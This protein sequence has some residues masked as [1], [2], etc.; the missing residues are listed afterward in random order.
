MRRRSLR[1]LGDR[2]SLITGLRYI[3]ATDLGR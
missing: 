3:D 1:L 2:I